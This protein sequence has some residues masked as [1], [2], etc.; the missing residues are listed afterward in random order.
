MNQKSAR[1]I[2]TLK[3]F[4]EW[5]MR[6]NVPT[7]VKN[8]PDA[9]EEF[10]VSVGRAYL[11]EAFLE[12]FGME[13]IESEPTKNLPEQNA[14]ME[15][16]KEHFDK[17]LGKFVNYH[18]FHLGVTIDDKVQNYGLSLIELFVVLM[19]FKDTV[20]EGDGDRNVI[21]WKYLLWVFKAN[22]NLSKYAIEGMYFL[23][24]VKCMLTHQM[25]E[26]V[27]W[28]RETNKKGKIGA[29]M[30]NDLEMEH[31]IKSTKTLITS[32]G[33]NKTE[34]A[35]LRSSMSV[36]GVSKSLSAYDES[37]NVI[38]PSTARTKKSAVRDERIMLGDLRLLKPFKCVPLHEPHPSFPGMLKS[39]REKINMGEFFCWLE[40]HKRQLVRGLPVVPENEES[41]SSD[42]DD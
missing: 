23:T 9:Y 35:V 19:Q 36:I 33:A 41:E 32:M 15:A 1:E 42:A 39:V 24:L 16:K 18:V 26:R 25:S 14:S 29:N 11:V 27:I 13:N 4:R 28:G 21:N 10:F 20:H 8:N 12:F 17:V 34:K 22:N 31:T 40:R 37:S 7:T 5:I 2:G 38:P 30:P 6:Y 3:Y